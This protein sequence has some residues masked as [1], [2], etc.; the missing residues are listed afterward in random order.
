Q[1]LLE[2]TSTDPSPR[3]SLRLRVESGGCHGYKYELDLTRS[4]WDDDVPFSHN[5]ARLVTDPASLPLVAGSTLDFVDEL[6]GS[7]FVLADNPNESSG[8]GCGSSF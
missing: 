8:C 7:R 1:R 2:I 6:I 3:S 5:G 4:Y